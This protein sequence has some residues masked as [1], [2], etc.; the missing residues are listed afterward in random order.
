VV[1]GI[2]KGL[3]HI[4]RRLGQLRALRVF[5]DDTDL[6]A[7][8]D[9]WGRITDALDRSRFMIVTLSPQAA[10]SHW[11][12]KEISYWLAHRGGDQLMLVLAAGELHWDENA[13]RFD[14]QTSD[15]APPAL[16][17]P[18]SLPAE[19]LFIEVGADAPW[20]Y[21]TPVFREKITALAAPIHGKPKDQLS[22]EDLREQRRF[23][24]LRAAAIAGL[25]L[26]TVIAVVAAG[27]AVKQRQQAVRHLHEA[28]V[29]KLNAEG[30]AML[31]GTTPGGDIRAL[32]ELLAARAINATPNG[33][34]ILDAQIARFTTEKIIPTGSTVRQLAYSPDG[35]RIATAQ[36]DGT[37]RQWQSTDGKT[38][39]SPSKA[40]PQATSAVAYSPDG[41][42][43]ASTGLDGTMQL[44]DVDA[45]SALSSNR[46]G[47]NS[48]TCVAISPNGKLLI[49]GANDDTIKIF[50][51]RT[52][53]LRSS[54]E[55]FDQK[56]VTISDITFDRSG[57]LFAVSGNNG[58][59]AIFDTNTGKLH[60][61]LISLPGIGTTPNSVWRIAFS[62]DGHTIALASNDLQ[63]WDADKGELI[64]SIRVGVTPAT[65]VSALAFSH[66][67][68]RLATG[69][70][71]GVVQLWDA[72]AG[73]QLGPSLTGHT[74]A[75][76]G[77]AFSPADRQI[78]T[79]S[80]DQT[81]RLWNATVGEPMSAAAPVGM[82]VAFSP[83]GHQVAASGDSIVA[84]WDVSTGEALPALTPGGAGA[85]SL[86][87]V[88]NDRIITAAADGTVEVWNVASGRSLQPPLHLPIRGRYVHFAVSGDGREIALGD[89]QNATVQ[90]WELPTGRPL[91]E[92]MT[93]NTTDTSMYGLAFSPDGRHLAA[94]YSDGLRIWDTH[95][96][97]PT[98]AT[99][100]N[101][102]SLPIMSVAFNRDGT[103][104][105][106]GR[107]DGAVE[108]WDVA[109][110]K[111]LPHSPLLG[112]TGQ[113]FGAAF[114]VGSQL[115][116]A[117]MDGSIRLWDAT[118]GKPSAAPISRT[119]AVTS[120]AVSA[121]GKLVA[122]ASLAG[123]LLLSPAVAD[124]AS[125][126]AKLSNNMSH[127]QWRDWV[128][129]D[130]GYINLCP[131]LP[132]TPG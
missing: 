2:Q 86:A 4:G 44:S 67:G 25:T 114:G 119:D 130:I 94:G 105:A 89:D 111:P 58:A 11:V 125:L 43:I 22:S 77:I 20:D 116:T 28:V 118:S 57:Q 39:G 110:R 24:R 69:R 49:A 42:K 9:L 71:D 50:D 91:G 95:T 37:V 131:G 90:L 64:R 120:V 123:A 73:S 35:A 106:A 93:V 101:S 32:Q 26:L 132:T 46:S 85:K 7:S 121:D 17:E 107:E 79:A 92:A 68:H 16:T 60:G 127:Q 113:V 128:S 96:T 55:V 36:D 78:A 109:T 21:H 34:P 41:K 45:G 82:V 126:C 74:A 100:P 87:F 124:T 59:V 97:Q 117:G 129:P 40:H 80:Q 10:A 102:Q 38:V 53:Q 122:S 19:P 61:G 103:I 63:L 3:H 27:V 6:T 12:N 99:L 115:A 112:H 104:V 31:A 66:D 14:P 75:V 23:R 15:A 83:D 18:G 54:Q 72:D 29:A 76:Y 30:S 62:P 52:G 1:S 33:V 13:A 8:P 84:R 88:A 81:L 98:G 70:G 108:L 5:R 51:L 65:L 47:S 56:A 48:L